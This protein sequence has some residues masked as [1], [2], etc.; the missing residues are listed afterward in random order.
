MKIQMLSERERPRNE[1][2]CAL[3]DEIHVCAGLDFPSE[4]F[5]NLPE[6]P[7]ITSSSWGNKAEE[8]EISTV[9]RCLREY[10]DDASS[11]GS[12]ARLIAK[13]KVT[14][15]WTSWKDERMDVRKEGRKEGRGREDTRRR[16]KNSTRKFGLVNEENLICFSA[17]R[18]AGVIEHSVVPATLSTSTLRSFSFSAHPH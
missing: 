11:V 14:E 8:A 12:S 2:K 3:A 15:R 18:R 1:I 16:R 6:R 17:R 10:D 4:R 5:F 13:K 9:C 7:P